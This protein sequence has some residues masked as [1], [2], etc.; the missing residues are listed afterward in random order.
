MIY[1]LS[2]REHNIQPHIDIE[3]EIFNKKN[4]L[5]TFIIAIN[6]GN[7]VNFLVLEEEDAGKTYPKEFIVQKFTIA[8]NS[9]ECS[10]ADA[11]WTSD[12]LR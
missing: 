6:G 7:I 8:Y 9:G 1:N 5:F 3:N 11:I 10:Q 4:G 12:F 2:I